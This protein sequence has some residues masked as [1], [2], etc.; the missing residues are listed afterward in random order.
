MWSKLLVN[1][2]CNQAAMVFQC[3]Y[4]GLKIGQPAHDTMVGAMKEVMAVANAEGIRLTEADIR[5][6]VDIIDGF[7]DDGEPS[8][9][10]DGKAHRKSEVELF[11][12]TIRRLGVKHGIPTPVNDWLYGKVQEMESQ[13]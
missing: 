13:Y 5:G 9:R 11:S 1:T 6:W 12:G 10:Q 3:G 4:G 8:M 2:G 7:P